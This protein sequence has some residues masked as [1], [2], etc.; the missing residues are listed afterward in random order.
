MPWQTLADAVLVLHLAWIVFLAGGFLLYLR[1]GWVRLKVVHAA[2]LGAM[3][4][5]QLVRAWCPLTVIEEYLRRKSDPT[6]TYRGSWIAAWAERVVYLRV[7]PE[8]VMTLTAMLLILA[9]IMLAR[10]SDQRA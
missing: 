7:P 6:F 5:M 1:P 9:L 3:V 4:V 8:A 10:S 2:S